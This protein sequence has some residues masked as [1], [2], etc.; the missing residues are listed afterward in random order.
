MLLIVRARET[1]LGSTVEGQTLYQ[2]DEG[3][4]VRLEGNLLTDPAEGSEVFLGRNGE[5]V[6]E[7]L[8]MWDHFAVVLRR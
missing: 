1:H 5:I 7:L 2:L 8:A 4:G 3:D 6:V